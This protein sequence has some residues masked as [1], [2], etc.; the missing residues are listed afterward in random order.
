MQVKLRL[1]HIS[2][3]SPLHLPHISPAS[4]QVA[5]MQVKLHEPESAA[6]I[7]KLMLVQGAGSTE[8]ENEMARRKLAETEALL[9]PLQAAAANLTL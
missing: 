1:P 6:E 7:Y 3:T 2:P 8:R 5:N 9:Q 4:P